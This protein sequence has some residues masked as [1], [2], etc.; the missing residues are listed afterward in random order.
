MRNTREQLSK[1]STRIT[2]ETGSPITR[3]SFV[4]VAAALAAPCIVPA[5]VLGRT[6]TAP[7]SERVT[8]G[9]IGTGG[10]GR[11]NMQAL[12]A[13]PGARAGK[14]MYCE[15]PL[16][17]AVTECGAI[18]NAVR[19]YQRVFQ[20]GTQQRSDANFA[21]TRPLRDS[22]TTTTPTACSRDRCRVRGVCDRA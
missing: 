7:P 9:I 16:G 2:C 8:L 6:G 13:L 1:Q 12:M 14:D 5:T 22:S 4:G 18:R 15:K 19:R 11:G 3:R 21:G 20:T 17:V 10:R